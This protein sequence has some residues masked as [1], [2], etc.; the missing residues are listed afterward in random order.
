MRALLPI[1]IGCVVLVLGGFALAARQVVVW[2]P[3]DRPLP[4]A[5]IGGEVPPTDQPLEPWLER[6]AERLATRTALLELPEGELHE[7]SF[8]ELGLHLDV[9]TTAA[10]ALTYAN[11]G[12]LTARLWRA[13]RA[14]QGETDLELAWRLDIAQATKA[15]GAL[16]SRVEREPTDARVDLRARAKIP[17][18]AGRRLDVAATVAAIA[19]GEREDFSRFRLAVTAVPAAVTSEMLLDVD[20]TLVLAGYETDFSN[21]GRGREAN[22]RLA[23]SRLNGVVLAPGEQLAFN[24]VVGPRT[25]ERGFDWAPE[26]YDDEMVPGIGGG[27]CQVASTLHAAA[28]MGGLEI[29]RRRPHSRPS[30]Y[31]PL[32]LD[33]TVIDGEVD[34]ILRNPYPVPLVLHADEPRSGWLRIEF[35]GAELDGRIEY[36][37]AV[38][39]RF[40]FYR[41]I[42]TK[43]DLEA[44]TAERQQKGGYGYDVVSTVRHR[45]DDG[46]VTSRQYRSEYR[47][48]P[49]V[50]WIGAG[51]VAAV[52]PPLPEGANRVV[53][54]GAEFAAAGVDEPESV[55]DG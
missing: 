31:I 54:D 45:H 47:P 46:R 48:T 55:G 34:L 19:G 24:E 17:E 52:L 36:R 21:T 9:A 35:L 33:A 5:F 12:D 2:L 18:I 1:T 53:V 13:H 39:E 40:P 50:Y 16:R 22:V 43:R 38:R 51:A 28:V 6:R 41:R 26:I 7:I 29:V 8:G 37:F 32:G 44:G 25:L 30:S 11:D 42:S 27:T 20:V 3:A 14:R 4:G 15:I 10:R 23:A 49:E